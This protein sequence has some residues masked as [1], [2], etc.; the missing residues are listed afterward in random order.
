MVHAMGRR[1]VGDRLTERGMAH[2]P[3]MP[4]WTDY[5]ITMS[6]FLQADQVYI[7]VVVSK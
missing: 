3:A 6:L 5:N 1:G 7:A 2:S 4:A